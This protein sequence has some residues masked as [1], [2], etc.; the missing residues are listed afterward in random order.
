M[1]E[2]KERVDTK[3]VVAIITSFLQKGWQPGDFMFASFD[4]NVLKKLQAALPSI[5][6]VVL[7]GWSSIRAA[8]RARRLGT[9]YLSMDQSYLWWGVV[10]NL[11]RNYKLFTYPDQHVPLHP[12][13]PVRPLRWAKY[14]LHGIITDYPDRFKK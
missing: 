8:S 11:T 7:E 4:Y 10:R 12:T 14:G 2:V 3:P 6:L 1:I 5:E 9:E 13:D